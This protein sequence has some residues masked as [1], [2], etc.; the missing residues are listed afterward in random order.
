MIK[1]RL[2]LPVLAA[3][4]AI[5]LLA[6]CGDSGGGSST[7]PASV[8]PAE[9]PVFINGEIQPTGELKTNLEEIASRIAG[10]EDLG[11][12][13]VSY[14]E[15]E[16]SEGDEPIDFE[17]EIE[18]WLGESA[19]IF[20]SKF[21]GEDFQG[22]GF[23][24]EV[25]DT[26][27]AQDF[28]DKQ[29]E[30]E[31]P[32]S[33]DESYE[34]V[35]YKFDADDEEAI[36]IVGNFIVFGQDK[37]TFEEAVDA[38]EGD[39]LADSD[40][41]NEVTPSSPEGSLADVYVDVGGLIEAAGNEVDEDALKFFEAS[42]IDIRKASALISLVPGANNVEID[43]AARLGG[44]EDSVPTETADQLLGT[45]PANSIAAIGVGDLGENVG[46]AIDT[47]DEQGI[48]GEVPP[49]QLK[50]ALENAGIDIDQITGNLGDAA[51]FVQGKSEATLS[52]ALVIEAKDANEARNTVSNVG[53]LLRSNGTPGVTAISGKA[54]GFSVRSAE[55]GAQPVVVAAKD[56]RIAV[57]YGLPATL[58]GLEAGSGATLAKTNAYN[59]ALDALGSTP[60]TGFAAGAP[61]LR[62]V[63]GLLTDPEE[64]AELEELTPYLTKVPFLAIG[65][66]TK[67]DVVQAKVILGVTE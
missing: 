44:G 15:Q 49:N 57:G 29:A 19:G 7:D 13:I 56:D 48:P 66:E 34:G 18:P 22:G 67:G 12:T 65:S 61:A 39:S 32:P 3:A 40:T 6:G 21:D 50:K 59:E 52:G 45:M 37:A 64:K 41:Y 8:A 55:L 36:G 10:V 4:A 14:I 5:A 1:T 20:L 26:G 46:E 63:E 30:S 9:T 27:E 51:V 33:N 47:I 58:A 16:A 2:L 23:A 11:G 60:I 54:T 17:Q 42:G 28:L 24:L 62:L 38:S 35:D 31:D 53:T 25:T 43:V